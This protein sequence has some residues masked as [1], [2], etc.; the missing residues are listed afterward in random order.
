M[1]WRPEVIKVEVTSVELADLQRVQRDEIVRLVDRFYEK[2]RDDEKLGFNKVAQYF[3]YPGWWEGGAALHA[4]IN[5]A[6]FDELPK[7]YQAILTDA[8]YFANASMLA[9]YDVKN[10]PALRELVAAGT[11]LRPFNREVLDAC[12]AATQEVYAEVTA[13][14]ASFKKIYDSQ[15]AFA[16]DFYLWAQLSENTFDTYMMIQQQAGK[17]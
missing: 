4:L 10:P 12:N 2:V 1:D 11:Q 5:K 3:Y 16:K 7:H 6:K 14:S 8:C 17:L 15:R 13:Q 9:N